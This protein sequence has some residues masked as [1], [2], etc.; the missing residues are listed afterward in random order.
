MKLF[1]TTAIVLKAVTIFAKSCTLND[2][3]G[4]KYASEISKV[5]LEKRARKGKHL[6]KNEKQI[7]R[8]KCYVL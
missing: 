8:E 5:T 7:L 3:L 4:S 1:A 6:R 2:W